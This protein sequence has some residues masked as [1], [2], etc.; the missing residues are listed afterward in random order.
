M[1][2]SALRIVKRLA[3]ANSKGR[4]GA[5]PSD[6]WDELPERSGSIHHLRD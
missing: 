4:P 2:I 5:M 6:L 1:N 3:P